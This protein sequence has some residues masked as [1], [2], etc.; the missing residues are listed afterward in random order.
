MSVSS[1]TSMMCK[2]ESDSES[3]KDDGL[4]RAWLDEYC[5]G[6]ITSVHGCS[7][8]CN[9]CLLILGLS[10]PS[11]AEKIDHN[12]DMLV[13]HLRYWTTLRSSA[14][15]GCLLCIYLLDRWKWSGDEYKA[16]TLLRSQATVLVGDHGVEFHCSISSIHAFFYLVN[17]ACK[18]QHTCNPIQMLP[19]HSK[20]SSESNDTS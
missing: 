10:A 4:F 18:S 6:P 8:L 9:A 2:S 14:E 7:H 16:T 17:P 15:R 11:A 5:L 19:R 20:T 12:G 1:D 3:D 13:R